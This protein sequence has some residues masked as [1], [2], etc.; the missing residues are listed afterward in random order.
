MQHA[1]KIKPENL[2]RLCWAKGMSVADLARRIGVHRVTV[3]SAV[4]MPS[5]YGPTFRKIEEVLCA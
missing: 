1:K 3:H 4:A 2:K 5:R